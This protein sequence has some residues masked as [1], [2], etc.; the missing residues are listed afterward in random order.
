V[1]ALSLPLGLRASTPAAAVR[2]A[3]DTP[4]GGDELIATLGHRLAVGIAAV[5][6]VL[7]PALVVLSGSVALAGGERLRAAVADELGSLAATRPRLELADVRDGPVLA[8]ALQTALT[9]ARDDV[10][11]TVRHLPNPGSARPVTRRSP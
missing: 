1:L 11:D 8:G 10:F 4:G 7:D 3:L 9:A 2:K 6:A 5:V